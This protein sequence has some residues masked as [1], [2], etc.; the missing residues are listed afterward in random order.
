MVE[1]IEKD[2]LGDGRERHVRDRHVVTETQ[3]HEMCALF[4]GEQD[5][6]Y[7]SKQK[8]TKGDG[9]TWLPA[10]PWSSLRQGSWR[11]CSVYRI[12]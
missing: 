12:F 6:Q 5:F 2:Y 10:R 8:D 4:Q 7:I 11:W 1:G 3:I 9:D